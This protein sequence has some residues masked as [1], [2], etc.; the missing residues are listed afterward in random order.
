[1]DDP[2]SELKSNL[3]LED[4]LGLDDSVVATEPALSVDE[5]IKSLHDSTDVISVDNDE[6]GEYETD[7]DESLQKLTAADV[8]NAIDTLM[9]LSLFCRIRW[10]TF[11]HPSLTYPSYLR[12]NC[13]A[14]K[15]SYYPQL[16]PQ[17][18][19]SLRESLKWNKLLLKVTVSYFTTF[20]AFAPFIRAFISPELRVVV[21]FCEIKKN[22]DR[23]NVR[24]VE[25][26]SFGTFRVPLIKR[27]LCMFF[28]Y[29]FISVKYIK[30]KL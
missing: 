14:T 16:L 1:M 20:S 7:D 22:L 25:P 11:I 15:T 10:Y 9:D 27:Q 23:W 13:Q 26:F 29:Y 4:F 17:R 12:K 19:K 18:L 2:L 8:R 3:S 30:F 5:I 6:I 28:L 24:E 21:F